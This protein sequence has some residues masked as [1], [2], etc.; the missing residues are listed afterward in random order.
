MLKIA[1]SL[2]ISY[3]LGS[4]PWALVIGL[5]FFKKDIRNYGS[6]NLG[7]TNTAR[8]L[9]TPWGLLV[10]VLDASKA[11]LAMYITSF[12]DQNLVPY[13]GFVAAIGHCYP[14]FANFKGGKAVASCFGYMLG[15]S[16]LITHNVLLHFFTPIIIFLIIFNLTHYVSLSSMISTL[17]GGILIKYTG[18]LESGI[19]VIALSIFIIFRHKENI[20]RITNKTES[21]M[22]LFKK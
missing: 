16:I 10:I 17:V 22:Y 3:L 18:D 13:A 6:G 11:L 1:S 9:G 14:V 2:F 5:V 12:I 4:I 15:I 8:V 21:K 7:G 19:L 20:K